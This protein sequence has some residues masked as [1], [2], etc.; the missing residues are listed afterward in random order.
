MRVF[1]ASL[2][3]IAASSAL[4]GFSHLMDGFAAAVIYMVALLV[5]PVLIGTAIATEIN[6]RLE[7]PATRHSRSRSLP[8]PCEWHRCGG[9]GSPMVAMDFAWVCR[10]CDLAPAR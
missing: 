10:A 3:G 2:A 5:A 9:C 4:Y 7:S 8:E 1:L 6:R